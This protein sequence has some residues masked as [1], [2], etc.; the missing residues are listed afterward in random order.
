[1][2]KTILLIDDDA[3]LTATLGRYLETK[4]FYCLY[5]ANG[6]EALTLAESQTIHAVILDW[7]L[8]GTTGHQTLRS[9][10]EHDPLS[11]VLIL[12]GSADIEHAVAAVK[13]GAA[14][15]ITKP[16]RQDELVLRLEK[17]LKERELKAQVESLQAEI[18]SQRSQAH[19]IADSSLAKELLGQIKK[20]ASTEMTVILQG[21]SGTGKELLARLLHE[22]SPR[23]DGPI[24]AI[25]CG[26]IPEA[27]LEA[28][29]FGHERGAFTDARARKTGL[30]ELAS[31]GTLF[32]DEI[33][34]MPP[35]MQAKLLRAL[36]NKT[37]R[38]LGGK[39]DIPMD[40]RVICATNKKLDA[41][42]AEGLFRQDLFFRLNQFPIT[43]APLRERRDDIIP[44]AKF[45]LEASNRELGKSCVL[46]PEALKTIQGHSWP[47]NARELKN[48]IARSCLLSPNKITAEHLA[49]K[50]ETRAAAESSM[51]TP[52]LRAAREAHERD[53]IV[54]T[55]EKT[56]HN[57]RR[58]AK[59]LGIHRSVL[60]YKLKRLNIPAS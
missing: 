17:A 57:K 6:P 32:L 7:L 3:E 20:V 50:S 1:M 59:L 41:A 48:T 55:L 5:A 16:V 40:A 13:A 46:T 10:H 43:V 53:I 25:D 54:N 30:I 11:A 14:D 45:F 24:V 27:L 36:E 8:E 9:L 42:V 49:L 34:N 35:S 23:R 19:F 12:T 22:Q 15:Y 26:A 56:N 4:G 44:L 58:A 37:I 2:K 39:K 60:Y 51:P 18:K 28:E 21:E 47:G 33:T 31:G 29:L 38:R 52:Q